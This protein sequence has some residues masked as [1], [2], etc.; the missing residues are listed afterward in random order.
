[1]M[2]AKHSSLL[3][4]LFVLN[5]ILWFYMGFTALYKVHTARKAAYNMINDQS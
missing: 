2:V 1:M 3:S 4:T 5:I